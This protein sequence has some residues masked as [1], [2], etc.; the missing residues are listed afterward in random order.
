M[1]ED[2]P[3]GEQVTLRIPAKGLTGKGPPVFKVV[4]MS[5]DVHITQG[6]VAVGG[7][8]DFHVGD[9]YKVYIDYVNVK[10][11]INYPLVLAA[12]SIN[13]QPVKVEWHDAITGD[14]DSEEIAPGATM[15]IHPLRQR[16]WIVSAQTW[17]ETP[18]KKPW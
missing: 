3:R 11:N 5:D 13:R 7:H 14:D 8:F 4:V 2:I 1:P 9:E 6:T 18:K 10:L 17:G 16:Y 15:D 12:S